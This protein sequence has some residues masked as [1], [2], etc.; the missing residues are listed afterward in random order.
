MTLSKSLITKTQFISD[1]TR[2]VKEILNFPGLSSFR[3]R[4]MDPGDI[5]IQISVRHSSG[6]RSF[7]SLDN[8]WIEATCPDEEGYRK[9][10]LVSIL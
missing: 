6:V 2:S 10:Y 8:H 9:Y 3:L 5:H 7:N 1:V 4:E